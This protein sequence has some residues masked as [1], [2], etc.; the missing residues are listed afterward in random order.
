MRGRILLDEDGGAVTDEGAQFFNALGIDLAGAVGR[1]RRFC[2]PC[3]DWSE[4]RPHL[5]GA[6]GAALASHCFAQGWIT[7][8]KDS[9]AVAITTPGRNGFR[10]AFGVEIP[11]AVRRGCPIGP[12]SAGG[13]V[14]PR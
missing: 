8:I 14:E 11:S 5:G 4:R 6:V 7:R 3:A 9:R 2:H 1:R 13:L 10:A 12:M